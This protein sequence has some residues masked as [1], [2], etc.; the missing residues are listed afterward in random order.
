MRMRWVLPLVLAAMA[1]GQGALSYQQLQS[2]IQS[3]VKLGTRDKEIAAYLRKQK[4]S[5]SLTDVLIED[6]QGMGAG[7]QTVAALRELEEKSHGLPPPPKVQAIVTPPKPVEPPPPAEEQKRIIEE[8]RANALAYTKNLPDFLCLQWTRRYV[9]PSGQEGGWYKY[10]EIKA[11][12]SYFEQKEDY[13]V[14]SV[15]E[16]MTN[17]SYESLGGAI[18]TGEFGSVLAELFA[19]ETA[20][21]FT[22]DHHAVVRGRKAWVFRFRVRRERSQYHMNYAHERDIIAGYTGLVYIDKQT[23]RVLSVSSVSAEVP[24]DFPIREART[25]LDYG[26]TKIA[27]Q[28]FLLPTTVT[29]WMREDRVLTR[30]DIEFRMYRKFSTEATIAFDKEVQDT[31]SDDKPGDKPPAGPPENP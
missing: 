1:L 15:N 9:D 7:P 24:P 8:A 18:S 26:F 12:V 5:F 14:I 28:E 4:L 6:L 10:D 3:S 27:D 2:I 16:Q 30:N 23:N 13:K 20:A 17:R 19:P 29:V 31:K 22:W 25:R 11:R 21:E